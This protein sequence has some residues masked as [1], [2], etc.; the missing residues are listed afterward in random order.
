M[1]MTVLSPLLRRP[2]ATKIWRLPCLRSFHATP[3][4]GERQRPTPQASSSAE[5]DYYSLLLSSPLPPSVP[6][7]E[8]SSPP[9][10]P[11]ADPPS[12][13]PSTPPDPKDFFGSRLESPATARAQRGWAEARPAEPDNCCM[14]GCVN[15]VWD[16]F[17]EEMEEWATRQKLA[18]RM[19]VTMESEKARTMRGRGKRKG[20]EEDS[21]A[22]VGDMDGGSGDFEGMDVDQEG[23]FAGVP[24]GIREF[25][26]TEKR[27]REKRER[28]NAK[29]EEEETG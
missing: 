2:P 22:G 27:L 16:L 25:M 24:I 4:R 15:C 20:S 19:E 5:D 12:A 6:A 29:E 14:S 17:R 28:E 18:H 8:T 23:L 10:L 9:E 1:T 7:P 21:E 3:P 11:V 13:K 26:N